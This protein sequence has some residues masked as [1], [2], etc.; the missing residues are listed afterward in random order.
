MAFRDRRKP[1]PDPYERAA[2]RMADRS[3]IGGTELDE[4]GELPRPGLRV[5]GQVI[6]IRGQLLAFAGLVLLALLVRGG[7]GGPDLQRS[8]T[9]PALAVAPTVV[10]AD[11]PVRYA[12]VGPSGG[13]DVLLAVDAAALAPDLTAVPL[14]GARDT[15]VVGQRRALDGCRV[16]GSFPAPGS[17]G[18]HTV[19]A[20]RLTGSGGVPL[21]SRPLT[22]R[23]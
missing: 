8:C 16:T 21:A 12:L 1:G 14:P 13:G 11:Q 5:G 19:T 22:V 7:S 4:N 2:Q 20:F 6:G 18:A 10:A 23:G 17:P 9:T 3:G 15:K